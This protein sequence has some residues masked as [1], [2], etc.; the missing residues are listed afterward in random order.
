MEQETTDAVP[1]GRMGPAPLPVSTRDRFPFT[2]SRYFREDGTLPDT[3]LV[4]VVRVGTDLDDV[5][6]DRHCDR[7]GARGYSLDNVKRDRLDAATI[8]LNGDAD[9]TRATIERHHDMVTRLLRG[10]LDGTD[11]DEYRDL[12]AKVGAFDDTASREYPPLAETL[13]D[14]RY[15][16]AVRARLACQMFAVGVTTAGDESYANLVKLTPGPR[17]LLSEESLRHIPVRDREAVGAFAQTLMHLAPEQKK[18]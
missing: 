12:D 11:L 9:A 14:G 13:S 3:A 15:R 5:Q 2:P 18:S 1:A 4:V 8:L 17:G 16:V 7:L 6:L 10:D